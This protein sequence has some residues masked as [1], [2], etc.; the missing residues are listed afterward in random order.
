MLS[1]KVLN[2][3]LVSIELFFIQLLQK[4]FVRLFV[5]DYVNQDG[6]FN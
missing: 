2:I 1:V 3:V 5:V 6:Q 4:L